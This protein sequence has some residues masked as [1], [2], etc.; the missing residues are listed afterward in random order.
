MRSLQEVQYIC[1]E[2]ETCAE[3][4]VGIADCVACNCALVD[5]HG[6]IWGAA[7]DVTLCLLPIAFLLTVTLKPNP[8]STMF[9]LPLSAIFLLLIR[10]MYLKSNPILCFG[11]VT[12][13]IHEA[14]VPL[15]MMF[16][17]ILLFEK[18]EQTCCM[19][20]LLREIKELTNGHTVAE[21][22]TIFSFVT[23]LEGASGFGT[24][25]ALGAPMLASLGYPK[26]ESVVT[27]LLMNSYSTVW[28]TLGMSI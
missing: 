2:D 15:S 22:M 19:P 16:G 25:I 5:Q 8:L 20:H 4:C 28:G 24:P 18:M 26:V 1:E 11:S 3:T 14:L 9:S 7:G 13:G 12:L 23:V 6:G 10:L 17:A 21:L 27:L